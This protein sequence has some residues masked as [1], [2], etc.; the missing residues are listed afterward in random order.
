MINSYKFLC[1]NTNKIA[2][3]PSKTG[4]E[5]IKVKILYEDDAKG[6]VTLVKFEGPNRYPSF[7]LNGYA[8]YIVLKG[9]LYM[10]GKKHSEGTFIHCDDGMLIDPEAK[11]ICTVLCIYQKKDY[12]KED[13]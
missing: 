11:G 5:G 13:L 7:I 4:I 8:H 3:Q 1:L 9:I 6:L 10:S 2:W 12:K